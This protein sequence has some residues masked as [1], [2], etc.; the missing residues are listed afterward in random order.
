MI[1]TRKITCFIN[2][3]DKEKYKEYKQTL[4]TWRDAVR[5]AANIVASH[6]FV[7][8]NIRD[9][10]Y[11]KD[12]IKEKFYIKDI[13]R[14]EP[15]F[16]EQ[17]VTYRIIAEMF[18]A[19]KVP[20]NI[21][22]T[23]NQAVSKVVNETY[24]DIWRGETA[25]RTYK[26]NIP[27]PF[28]GNSIRNL[29]ETEDHHFD[30][31]LFKIPFRCRLGQDHSNNRGL[32]RKIIAGETRISTS[33]IK[34]ENALKWNELKQCEEKQMVICLLLC[35]DQPEKELQL[36]KEKTLTAFLGIDVPI[37]CSSQPTA[38]V[39]YESGNDKKII[40]IGS[41]EEFLH[42]RL[43]IQAA[44]RE[45]QKGCRTARGGHGRKRKLQALE[46]WHEVEKKYV[47]QRMHEYSH[48][49]IEIAIKEGCGNIFLAK[50][51][52]REQEAREE[53]LKGNPFILRNWSYYK[54]KQFIEYKAKLNGISVT[55]EDTGEGT[56][57]RKKRKNNGSRPSKENT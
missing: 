5:R 45:C 14:D 26:N 8:H 52:I 48:Q 27:I 46:H 4:Y 9:F 55:A 41:R 36:D 31:I 53:A 32:L 47:E 23:L 11:L 50:Q 18:A 6:K 17:N 33:S 21:A 43:R 51:I 1:I 12:E 10:V 3:T 20:S 37:L 57:K 29:H 24:K 40:S 35:Y 49:L 28:S 13:L 30:F 56:K 19:Y 54:L 22:S 15:G 44:L 16:S 25:L 39:D 38:V 34:I 42:R 2:E 7:Q